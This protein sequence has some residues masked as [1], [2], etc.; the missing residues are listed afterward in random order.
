MKKAIQWFL[1]L[2][3]CL[4]LLSGE[5]S[6]SKAFGENTNWEIQT[7]FKFDT[8][9]FL[10]SL[11]GDPYYLKYYQ[12]EYDMFKS[13]FT[14]S[15]R[16]AL[17]NLKRKVREEKN[18]IISAFLCLY[19]SAVNDVSLDDLLHTLQDSNRMRSNLKKTPYFSE[20]G[21]QLYESIREEINDAYVATVD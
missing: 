19:F 5:I 11:T 20:E 14:P 9:C 18:T 17:Q 13:K 3:F 16:A 15:M 4:C 21:W 10:N 8:L 2:G 1:L 7:S 6:A 12:A